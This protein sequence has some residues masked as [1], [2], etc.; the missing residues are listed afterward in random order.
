ML[1]FRP[2]TVQTGLKEWDPADP[3]QN[4]ISK[5]GAIIGGHE[6]ALLFLEKQCKTICDKQEEILPAVQ[7]LCSKIITTA[8]L[9][10]THLTLIPLDSSAY[11]H[12]PLIPVFRNAILPAPKPLSGE[13]GQCEGVLLQFLLAFSRLLC[14]FPNDGT[15][16]SYLV[17]LLRGKHWS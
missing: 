6:Q 15:K 16:L 11:L 4:V 13:L 7:K 1:A 9:P 5:Q 3:M 10:P 2:L 12:M 14:S 8:H 17:V